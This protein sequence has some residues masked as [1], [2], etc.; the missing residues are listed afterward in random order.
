[1]ISLVLF[2]SVV[3]LVVA[4]RDPRAALFGWSRARRPLAVGL[5]G[6][7]ALVSGAA[8]LDRPP[9]ADPWPD[10]DRVLSEI[11]QSL[12]AGDDERAQALADSALAL[13][14]T[15]DSGDTLRALRRRAAARLAEAARQREAGR[16]RV[17]RVRRRRV[18]PSTNGSWTPRGIGADRPPGCC[19]KCTTGKPCGNS[20]IRAGATCTKPP[21][22]TC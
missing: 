3:G 17:R 12:D 4:L 10:R 14:H 16:V 1:M 22:C 15:S 21:G 8:V 18:A 6:T 2:V 20:C 9:P 13:F 19:R 5:Y 7:A 11:R